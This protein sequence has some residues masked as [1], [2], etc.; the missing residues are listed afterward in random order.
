MDKI[1]NTLSDLH[2]IIT[3]I[4]SSVM[5]FFIS[6]FKARHEIRKAKIIFDRA[7]KGNFN[8]LFADLLVATNVCSNSPFQLLRDEA[9]SINCDLLVIAPHY[10]KQKL[11]EMD[12]ALNNGDIDKINQLRHELIDIYR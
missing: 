12:I 4:I 9:I 10:M 1:I 6:W 3:V 11:K 2:P 7:D 8:K 5:S